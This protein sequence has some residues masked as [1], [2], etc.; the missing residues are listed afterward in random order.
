MWIPC[1]TFCLSLCPS[2]FL[3][4]WTMCLWTDFRVFKLQMSLPDT[5]PRISCSRT[6]EVSF[7][8]VGSKPPLYNPTRGENS[9]IVLLSFTSRCHVCS[10]YVVLWV[11]ADLRWNII[12]QRRQVVTRD[13]WYLRKCKINFTHG[14]CKYSPQKCCYCKWIE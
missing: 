7:K 10:S 11:P 6:S 8:K 2:Y 9:C 1:S 12:L 14:D 4:Y 13:K 5:R 3:T